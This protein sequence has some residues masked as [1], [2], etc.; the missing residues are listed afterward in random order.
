MQLQCHHHQNTNDTHAR[1]VGAQICH[2]NPE[3]THK[4]HF[5]EGS[6]KL[7]SGNNTCRGRYTWAHPRCSNSC[8]VTEWTKHL[9]KVDGSLKI[10][11]AGTYKTS[12]MTSYM[13]PQKARMP[14][15]GCTW[16]STN[17]G[18][19]CQS[20]REIMISYNLY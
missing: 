6:T 15:T 14:G 12:S 2:R 8:T 4:R 3:Q 17:T 20:S 11:W 16:T 13:S 18:N 9:G 10:T 19:R 7:S 1:T 5:Q